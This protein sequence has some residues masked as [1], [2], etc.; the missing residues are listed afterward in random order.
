MGK[1]KRKVTAAGKAEKKRRR[2]EY[3]TIFLG[4]KQKR[5]RRLPTIDGMDGDEFIRRNA[6]PVWLHQNEMWEYPE[7]PEDPAWL[8]S[9]LIVAREDSPSRE[10]QPVTCERDDEIPF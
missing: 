6:D 10:G 1:P 8:K 5:V 2:K 9:D 7:P 4:G 3:M